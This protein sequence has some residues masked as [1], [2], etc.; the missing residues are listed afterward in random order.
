MCVA[1][2]KLLRVD[3]QWQPNFE[4]ARKIADHVVNGISSCQVWSRSLLLLLFLL[5][6]L[7]KPLHASLPAFDDVF[8]LH[9]Q[10]WFTCLLDA[11]DGASR[12]MIR[13]QL[14]RWCMQSSEV[15]LFRWMTTMMIMIMPSICSSSSLNKFP[16]RSQFLCN[17]A[18]I[19]ELQTRED[20]W[21][22]ALEMEED[23]GRVD[24]LR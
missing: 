14:M 9:V 10:W 2:L 12:S 1:I 22:L 4:V 6:P 7:Y 8:Q 20:I 5:L 15:M 21:V 24:I 11:K 19:P 3:D 18:V 17:L 16:L 13:L 23:R